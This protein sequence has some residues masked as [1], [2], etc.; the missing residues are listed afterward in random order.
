MMIEEI[1]NS[2]IKSRIAGQFLSIEEDEPDDV[3]DNFA[4]IGGD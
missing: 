1:R 3:W 2:Q 4:W